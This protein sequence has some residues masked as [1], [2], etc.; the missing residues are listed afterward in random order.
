MAPLDNFRGNDRG[1]RDTTMYLN[2]ALLIGFPS[3]SDKLGLNRDEKPYLLTSHSE[4]CDVAQV[5]KTKRK[6]LRKQKKH[7]NRGPRMQALPH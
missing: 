1:Q 4:I 7:L 3:Q 6:S 2:G 5:F